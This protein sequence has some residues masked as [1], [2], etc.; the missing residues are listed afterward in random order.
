ME[1]LEDKHLEL[2]NLS[3]DL[4]ERKVTIQRSRSHSPELVVKRKGVFRI[5]VALVSTGE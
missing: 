4:G 2:Y 3:E 5:G 1:F